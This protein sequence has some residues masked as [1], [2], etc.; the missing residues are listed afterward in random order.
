MDELEPRTGG[1]AGLADDEGV[2][3]ARRD[4]RTIVIV[5]VEVAAAAE[6][7]ERVR[8]GGARREVHL[9]DHLKRVRVE[10]RQD[11]P[12]EAHAHGHQ[13]AKAVESD[14]GA[15]AEVERRARAEVVAERPR[16]QVRVGLVGVVVDVRAPVGRHERLLR[17]RLGADGTRGGGV[18]DE[19]RDV[20]RQGVLRDRWRRLPRHLGTGQRRRAERREGHA[21]EDCGMPPHHKLRLAPGRIWLHPV[22]VG[23]MPG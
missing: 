22:Q 21:H 2:A 8:A 18:P 13:P 19:A 9:S 7:L 1:A 6:V 4:H 15:L 12:V 20:R 16:L 23:A 14:R 3:V 5:E 10:H 11:R 17:H